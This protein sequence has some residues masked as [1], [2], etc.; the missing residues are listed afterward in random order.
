MDKHQPAEDLRQR[1]RVKESQRGVG[2]S[3][4]CPVGII[5]KAEELVDRLEAKGSLP[6]DYKPEELYN[7]TLADIRH[8]YTNYEDLLHEL[9]LCPCVDVPCDKAGTYDCP[10]YE[11]SP[12]ESEY[13]AHETLKWPAKVLAE[14]LYGEWRRKQGER[15]GG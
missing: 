13:A 4:Q 5:E 10:C 9:P 15:E 14:R 7:V 6:D 12:C 8:E 3:K 1:Q 2:V 11:G